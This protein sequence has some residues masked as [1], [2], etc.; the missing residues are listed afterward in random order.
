M[1]LLAM[2]PRASIDRSKDLKPCSSH[3]SENHVLSSY[4]KFFLGMLL[5]FSGESRVILDSVKFAERRPPTYGSPVLWHY[6]FCI[7]RT[8]GENASS[9]K[10]IEDGVMG[11]G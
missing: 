4:R 3:L 9:E 10:S 6:I 11:V 8:K 1:P 5:D 7:R 2:V